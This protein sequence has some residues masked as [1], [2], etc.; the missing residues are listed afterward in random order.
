MV[1]PPLGFYNIWQVIVRVFGGVFYSD[2]AIQEIQVHYPV[3]FTGSYANA[4][5]C[6]FFYFLCPI[7]GCTIIFFYQ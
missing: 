6:A 3:A 2:R 4:I 5:A 1:L 7:I